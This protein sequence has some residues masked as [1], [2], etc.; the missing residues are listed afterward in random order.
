M[1]AGDPHLKC[2]ALCADALTYGDNQAGYAAA[3]CTMSGAMLAV[4]AEIPIE[5]V[6]ASIRQA[7]ESCEIARALVKERAS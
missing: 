7:Y 5:T 6:L 3:L 2:L 1:R 4:Q